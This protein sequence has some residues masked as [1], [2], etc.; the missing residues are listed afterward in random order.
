[1]AS[2][3]KLWLMPL[4]GE[5]LGNK[6]STCRRAGR[7]CLTFSSAQPETSGQVLLHYDAHFDQI[8]RVTGQPC[9]WVAA[10]RDHRLNHAPR[11][12]HRVRDPRP[13]THREVF[14]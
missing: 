1:M 11:S 12:A 9:E 4:E 3:P 7:R 6:V 2:S 10:Q 5:A 14:Q 8:G 13:W